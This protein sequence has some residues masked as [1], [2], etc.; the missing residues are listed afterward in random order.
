M[1]V[2]STYHPQTD[3][4]IERVNQILEQY[5]WCI[6]SYQREDWVDFL[7]MLEFAYSIHASTEV[8]PFFANY[9]FHPRFNISILA[10]FVNPS[11]K[12]CACTLQDVHHDLSLELC[13]AGNQYKDEADGHCL[14]TPTF[15]VGDM[16]W[17]ARC[18]IAIESLCAKLDYKK[19]A[20][21]I[22]ERIN[23]VAF[24]LALPPESFLNSRMTTSDTP[25]SNRTKRKPLS[26]S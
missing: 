11:P 20:F 7:A 25:L 18:R 9:G 14:A 3:G 21:L 23:Q 8:S 15:A 26:L 24:W 12:M 6:V 16:V 10:N 17:L 19:L 1:N 4:Q 22:M 5:L 2:S 13:I